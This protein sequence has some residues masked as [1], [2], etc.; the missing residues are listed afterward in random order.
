MTN[1]QRIA[2]VGARSF[3]G[4]HLAEAASAA[5]HTVEALTREDFDATDPDATFAPGTDI[6]VF[7][8]QDRSYTSFDAPALGVFAVNTVGVLNAAIK[9]HQVGARGLIYTSTGNVYRPSFEPLAEHAPLARS[10]IYSTSKIFAEQILDLVPD[11]LA[12]VC[13]RLFGAYGPNQTI[14]LLAGLTGRIRNGTPVTLQPRTHGT[15][16]GGFRASLTHVDDVAAGLLELANR[17]GHEPLPRTINLAALEPASIEDVARA[18]G[19]AVGIEPIIEDADSPRA[20]D[21]IA[22]TT[23]MVETLTTSFRSIATGIPDSF[24]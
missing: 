8:A 23:L 6:V 12:V 14:G 21:L 24:R 1:P 9:A 4:T 16:D 13:P 22:D 2:I 18:I 20:F 3:I 7:L 10:D 17:L 19:G 11:D 15:P 5:G